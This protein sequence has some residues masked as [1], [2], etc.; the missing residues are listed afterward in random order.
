[1]SESQQVAAWNATPP[2]AAGPAEGVSYAGFWIRT[3]AWMIDAVALGILT[4][5]L[6]PAFGT[7]PIIGMAEGTQFQVDYGANAI[8]GLIGLVYWVGLWSWKGQTLGMMPFGLWVV[9]ADNG[10]RVDVVTGFLRYVG[11][12][13]SFAVILLGVIWVAFDSRKQ[14]WHDKLAKTL[15]VRR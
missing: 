6:A 7:G 13:I 15:V 5:A 8:G 2:V 4:S 14:G 10:E 3:V 11:L 12:I 1:M 9:R